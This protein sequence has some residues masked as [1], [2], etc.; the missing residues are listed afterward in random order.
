MKLKIE[1]IYI[2]YAINN[3]ILISTMGSLEKHLQQIDYVDQIVKIADNLYIIIGVI[4]AIKR[5]KLFISRDNVM[6][7]TLFDSS[8]TIYNIHK[9]TACNIPYSFDYLKD[10]NKILRNEY[11]LEVTPM[12]VALILTIIQGNI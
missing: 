11:P 7:D 1:I 4:A 2:I 10:K 8:G 3:I 5:K 6:Y 9:V 12:S